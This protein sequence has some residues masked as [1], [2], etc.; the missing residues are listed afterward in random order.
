ME[1]SDIDALIRVGLNQKEIFSI[2]FVT[3]WT[4]FK[5]RMANGLEYGPDAEHDF[6][7]LQS[8]KANMP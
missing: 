4:N 8:A 1:K 5:N 3:A 6:T 2:V 7:V